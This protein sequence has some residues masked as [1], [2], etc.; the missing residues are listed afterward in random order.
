MGRN[1][2]QLSQKQ[3]DVLTWVKDGC[4]SG[5]FD[6]YEHRI[7]A[8]GLHNRGFVTVTGR[9]PTWDARITDAGRTWV[10]APP[11]A[12][13]PN[14][15]A[16]DGLVARVVAAGGR[17]QL[18]ED[19][20]VEKAHERLVR[21]SLMSP[22]RPKGGKLQMRNT[23]RWGSGPTEVVFVEHFDDYVDPA[24]VPVPDRVAKQHPVVKA[25]L[26]D[27]DWQYV[28]KE[29]LPRA[30][31]ILQAIADEAPRRGIDVLT[32]QEAA[33]GLDEYQARQALRAHLVLKTSTGLY[34]IQ[35][36]EIPGS[37][38]K[39]TE[40]RRWNERKTKPAWIDVRGWEFLSTGKLELIVNGPGTRYDGDRY[41]DAKALRVEDKLPEAFRAL[42]IHRLE[43]EHRER[44]RQRKQA[45]RQLGWEAAME[46]ARCRYDQHARWDHFKDRSRDWQAIRQHREFLAAA[47]S[48]IEHVG[49][50]GTR[51][52]LGVQLGLA[53][54]L[55]DELDAVR[56]P[57]LLLPP[58]PEPTPDDLKPFLDG[59][60]PYGPNG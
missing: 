57:E 51:A 48:A 41:R 52:E 40:P 42:D 9:G 31:R 50:E 6:G 58:V 16:A 4:P 5:V 28:T 55:L 47:R 21:M 33:K 46:E 25:F 26:A 11:A 60:S 43:S 56:H 35:I 34:R 37:G 20:E 18:P 7:V 12:V 27:K 1:P 24:P 14:Q 22:N 53:E 10:A 39:K 45:E 38:A 44:E 29:H 15:S 54:R 3:V 8:R 17:L 59:W 49:D 2:S 36:R 13:L 23:G 19:P 30:A 32:P